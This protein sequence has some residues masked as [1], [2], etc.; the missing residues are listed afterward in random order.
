MKKL[1]TIIL[2]IPSL[3]FPQGMKYED[4]IEENAFGYT[5]TYRHYKPAVPSDKYVIAFHGSGEVGP[6]DGSL[7]YL[8]ERHGLPQIAKNYSFDF[9]I[10]AFQVASSYS[11][12]KKF[13]VP[14]VKCRF[15]AKKIVVTGLSLGGIASYEIMM[16]DTAFNYIDGVAAVCGKASTTSALLL[17][18]KDHTKIISFHGDQDITVKYIEDKNFV[19]AYNKSHLVPIDFITYY[20]IG[21]AIW[22]KAY[23]I[24]PGED[25]LIQFIYKVFAE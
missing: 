24:K 15:N 10:I 23:S 3:C 18:K 7:L 17:N 14:Y 2:L 1:L 21:H 19:T 16:S 5:V 22:D 25:Q 20:G 9:N 6:I 4:H 13:V 12:L 11:N 8:V